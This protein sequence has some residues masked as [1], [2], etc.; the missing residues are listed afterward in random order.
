MIKKGAK[1]RAVSLTTGRQIVKNF[2]SFFSVGKVL[3]KGQ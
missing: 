2:F 1:F 3:S